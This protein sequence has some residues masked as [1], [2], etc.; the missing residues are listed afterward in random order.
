MSRIIRRGLVFAA[1]RT[2][3]IDDV[4]ADMERTHIAL[5]DAVDRLPEEALFDARRFPWTG[6]EPLLVAIAGD[7]YEHY[8]E[9]LCNIQRRR[10]VQ[11][12]RGAPG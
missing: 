1:S 11:P 12:V 4:L 10:A 9:H 7:T 2:R 3:H 6:G 5:V 8:S